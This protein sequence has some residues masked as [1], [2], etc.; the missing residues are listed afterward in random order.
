MESV[1]RECAIAILVGPERIASRSHALVIV[2]GTENAKMEY[3]CVT[4]T[5]KENCAVNT[6]YEF[7]KISVQIIVQEMVFVLM[8]SAF[9]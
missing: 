5:S 8:V 2:L 6:K 1:I 7:Y 4:R 9:A 3:A